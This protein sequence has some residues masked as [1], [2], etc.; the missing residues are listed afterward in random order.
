MLDAP[1]KNGELSILAELVNFF[2]FSSSRSASSACCLAL[3][4]ISAGWIINPNGIIK[5]ATHHGV[6]VRSPGIW[7]SV[8]MSPSCIIVSG[9]DILPLIINTAFSNSTP[10]KLA[11]ALRPASISTSSAVFLSVLIKFAFIFYYLIITDWI[12]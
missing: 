9:F 10:G 6:S 2:I 12:Q 1:R 8:T 7:R 5:V 3:Y 4:A 11:R